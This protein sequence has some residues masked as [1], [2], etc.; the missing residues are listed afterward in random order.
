MFYDRIPP[1][2]APQAKGPLRGWFRSLL[3]SQPEEPVIRPQILPPEPPESELIGTGEIVDLAAL[4]TQLADLIA[5]ARERLDG[6]VESVDNSAAE[7]A[8]YRRALN[9]GATALD[10]HRLHNDAVQALVEVTRAMI[11]RTETAE[12][13]LRATNVELRTLQQDLSVAQESAE[14]DPLTG[15]LNRRALEEGLKRAIVTARRADAALSVAFCD[16]DN[17]KRLNDVH[18]HSVGD[19]VLRLVGDCLSEDADDRTFVGRQ[20]GEEFV[21]LFEGLPV[22]EAAARIDAI[23]EALSQRT[24]RSRSDGI[25]IGRITFSA[26]VAA[27]NGGEDGEALLH[28]AD[29][30]LYRAKESG[31]N[32]VVIDPGH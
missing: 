31:R 8:D 5:A 12:Q 18:G 6:V 16:I 32:Q 22:I 28:R 10:A 4:A 29:Q 23:R 17:F 21:V 15:L 19:R 2:P 1:D 30:A 9:D 3:G 7:A 11:E 26:G 14:R 13:R 24:L 25:P 20:G 27:L